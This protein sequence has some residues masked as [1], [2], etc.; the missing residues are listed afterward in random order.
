MVKE[1]RVISGNV[2]L[3]YKIENKRAAIDAEKAVV[4]QAAFKKYIDC[5]SMKETARYILGEYGVNIDA[6]SMKHLLTNTWYIGKAYGIDGWCPAIIDEKTFKLTAAL[7]ETRG[8]RTIG[9]RSDR[10]YLFTGLVFCGRCGRRMTTYHIPSKSN[11]GSGFIYYRCP[12]RTMHTCDMDKQINQSKLEQWLIDNVLFEAER[13]NMEIKKRNS[14]KIKK[15]AD[16]SKITAKLEK[17]RDLYLSDLIT[18]EMYEQSYVAL[19][20]DLAE[21]Q[22][23]QRELEHT[24]IDTSI[25]ENFEHMYSQLDAQSRKAFWSRVIKKITV[26]RDGGYVITLNDQGF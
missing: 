17:L 6:K 22:Q 11:R 12:M 10:V 2:P 5:R 19:K 26:H 3:G 15:V 14:A 25:F 16:T 4:V 21:A 18:R 13:Y 23:K 1:G 8:Q 9:E 20:A 7:L 24:P